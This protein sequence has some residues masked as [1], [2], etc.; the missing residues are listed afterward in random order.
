MLADWYHAALS[1]T[2]NGL[3]S[4]LEK[5]SNFGP[6]VE[7]RCWTSAATRSPVL[8]RSLVQLLLLQSLRRVASTA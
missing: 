7:S 1:R 8:F 4:G 6:L 3:K 2:S 5:C